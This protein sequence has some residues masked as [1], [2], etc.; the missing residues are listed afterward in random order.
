M[1][2]QSI[3]AAKKAG[4]HTVLDGCP[5]SLTQVNKLA[6]QAE[7]IEKEGKVKN[8]YA[9]AIANFQKIHKIENGRWVKKDGA[10]EAASFKQNIHETLS[11]SEANIFPDEN[12]KRTYKAWWPLLR[13]GPGNTAGKNYYSP[14]ALESA[15][16][17]ALS[18]R[19]MFL[20]HVPGDVKPI[21]RDVRDWAASV[22]ETKIEDGVLL[23]KVQAYDSWLKERMY[24]AP[25]ELACSIEGRGKPSG[26]I[27]HNGEKWNLI[28]EVKWIN[29]FNIVDYPGNAPMGIQL[30]ESDKDLD[31]GESYMD[32]AEL[33]DKN[34][35]LYNEIVKETKE[36]AKAEF[37]K[38][39]KEK[40]DRVKVL[41]G[42]LK[43][44][45]ESAVTGDKGT[46]EELTL[47]KAEVAGLKA[48]ET[49]R[50]KKSK[51]TVI[52][53]ESGIPAEAVTPELVALVEGASD[54]DGM[55][56]IV[57]V[58]AKPFEGKVLG[59]G[60]SD[61]VDKDKAIKEREAMFFHSL[62]Q[63]TEEEIEAERKAAEKK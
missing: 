22:Q 42:E 63:K 9:V 34:I 5:L 62:G 26:T 30:T 21:E 16:P 11:L 1:P 4:M 44:L 47:L 8:G 7:A 57:A 24:D 15:A 46:K 53:R 39:V 50:D 49:M 31:E 59:H 19:K 23:G 52:V 3:E 6:E 14:K 60:K 61:P 36:A 55:K 56:K 20:G 10:K 29:A 40:E 13:V 41:E 32:I 27:D 35:D 48:A 28:E 12:G 25:G 38:A 18:R 58:Y 33:K 37:D 17:L 43:T 54:E 45:K 2:W 51:A